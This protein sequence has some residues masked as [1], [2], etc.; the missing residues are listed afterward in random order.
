MY[1]SCSL[2]DRFDRMA[3]KIAEEAQSIEDMV[4]LVKYLAQVSPGY[5]LSSQPHNP[6]IV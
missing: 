1:V 6:I 3:S 5:P 4:E 2:C